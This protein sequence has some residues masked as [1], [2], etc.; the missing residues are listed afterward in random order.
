MDL[1]PRA[2][3][4]Y[5]CFGNMNKTVVG[6]LVIRWLI[7]IGKGLSPQRQVSPST[8]SGRISTRVCTTCFNP[9]TSNDVYIHRTAQLTSRRCIL[10]IYSTNIFTEYFKHAAHSPF[11]PPSRCRLFHN[12]IFLGSCNIHIL[13]TGCAKIL[14][15]IPAPKG[16]IQT[17]HFA[18]ITD[19]FRVFVF[20][21]H[22]IYTECP[23]IKSLLMYIFY[24]KS[25]QLH[26]YV[27]LN[28]KN[29]KT[30]T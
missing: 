14:K 12:A 9:L 27:R 8:H 23:V 26:H 19:S 1:F 4:A 25:D 7:V 13:Y 6:S 16:N 3:F 24:T 15:K 18:D 20:M 11:P 10:N 29:N 28:Q 30:T 5:F 22:T 21:T 17:L 2:I